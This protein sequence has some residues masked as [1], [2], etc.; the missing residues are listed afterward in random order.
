MTN[1][2]GG[3]TTYQYD[4]DGNQ[5]AVTDPLGNTT[6]YAYDAMNRLTL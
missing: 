4:A 1:A 2:L 3:H 6:S 5:I